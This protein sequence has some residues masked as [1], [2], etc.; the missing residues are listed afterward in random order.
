MPITDPIEPS[1][2]SRFENE[3]LQRT[4]Q[5]CNDINILKQIALELLNLNQK[6]TAIAEWATRRAA[7]A[8]TKITC[9][10]ED[11]NQG[12]NSSPPSFMEDNS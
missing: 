2:H 10:K 11:F 5:E 12:F 6:Q 1:L 9:S 3:K 4:I 8:E 7:E